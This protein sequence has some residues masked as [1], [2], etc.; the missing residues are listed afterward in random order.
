MSLLDGISLEGAMIALEARGY[1]FVAD[2]VIS[3]GKAKIRQVPDG[4]A[5]TVGPRRRVVVFTHR[6]SHKLAILYANQAG[7]EAPERLH[8]LCETDQLPA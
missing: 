2:K 7:P 5:G 6:E 1:V 4:V 8:L 3:T